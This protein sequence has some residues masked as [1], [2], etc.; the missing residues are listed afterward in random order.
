M[1]DFVLEFNSF[2][3][4]SHMSKIKQMK[5]FSDHNKLFDGKVVC[6]TENKYVF[7]KVLAI[8]SAWRQ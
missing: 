8:Q 4:N 1:C 6:V 2:T 3:V 7:I 5:G